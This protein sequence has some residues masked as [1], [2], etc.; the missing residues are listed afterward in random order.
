MATVQVSPARRQSFMSLLLMFLAI[1][2]GVSGFLLV[3]LNRTGSVPPNTGRQIGIFVGVAVL[4]QIL[5]RFAAPYADPVILPIAVTLTGIGLSMMYRL[6]MSY[7]KL[8]L[9]TY[10]NRQG[11]FAI[12]SLLAAAGTL[13]LLRNHRVLRKYTYSFM[14]LSL[15]L[16]ILPTIPG[17]G[18]EI[19][20][21]R[22]WVSLFGF[23]FQ[24]A[25]FAKITL[26]IF[27]AGYLVAN[28]DKLSLGGPKILGLRLPRLRDLGP[29]LL[30]WL[31]SIAVLVLQQDLGTSL[32]LFGLFVAMLYVATN[33]ISWLIIGAI[34]FVPAPFLAVKMFPHV[35]NRFNVWLHALDPE[36][37]EAGGGSY[38]V[39]QGL[40]GMANGGLMGTG[41]GRGY[42]QLVPLAHSDF[43][44]GSLAEELGLVGIT[45]IMM[46]YL[47]LIERGLRAGLGTRDGFGKLLAS[48]LAFSFALQVFVVLGGLTRII[49]LTGLTA[50]FLAQG[51]SSMLTS[52]V[53]VALLLRISDDSRRPPQELKPWSLSRQST[54]EDP[55]P[56]TKALEEDDTTVTVAGRHQE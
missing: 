26:T 34:L 35:A 29:I 28:R 51:G 38:Q 14:V 4:A 1:S 56:D 32:L 47:I 24:P 20:G 9:G 13:L 55:E 40:F 23:Q 49:P 21:S 48:G 10:S 5:V 19:F 22:V 11:L 43:I 12:L 31:V 2:V 7:E 44:L 25:E 36:V 52:W 18:V 45:A 53:I 54:P 15:L 3:N 33:R 27:F 30:V 42:P 50:P 8:G 6:D 41:W 37:Y 39:V 46:L 16:L 17:L